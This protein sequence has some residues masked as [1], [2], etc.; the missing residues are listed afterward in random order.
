[1]RYRDNALAQL[2]QAEELDLP[3]R[4][5]RARNW[6]ALLALALAVA[7]GLTWAS[8]GA[9]TRTALGEGVLIH[10]QGAFP[11][12]SPV[13]GVVARVDDNLAPGRSV[14]AGTPVVELTT[15][16][17]QHVTVPVPTVVGG[18]VT[19]VLVRKGQ[20]VSAGTTL[21]VVEPVS[22][23]D[24]GL[25]AVLYLSP[26]AA[27]G[28]AVGQPVD[29]TV[30]GAAANP[31][32]R[33]RGT[34][35]SVGAAAQTRS[36]IAA[37]LSDEDLAARFAQ[38]APAVKVVVRLPEQTPAALAPRQLVSGTVHLAPVRLADW[39]TGA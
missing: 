21:A 4:Y 10:G 6:A 22:G 20:V 34:V 2:E 12:E 39:L 11:V 13:G 35:A 5:V 25:E 17:D 9:M 28:V 24:D 32:S 3:V 29:L 8:T 14:Q 38:D 27:G 30:Q 26:Q 19:A 7:A 36:E 1:M 15:G 16:E 23:P 31:R 33:L 37:F 18:L